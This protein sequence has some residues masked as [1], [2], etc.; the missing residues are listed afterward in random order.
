MNKLQELVDKRNTLWAQMQEVATGG[1]ADAAQREQYTQLE[2]ELD[3]NEAAIAVEERHIERA[4]TFA[5]R[6][7]LPADNGPAADDAPEYNSVFEKWLRHGITELDPQERTVLQTGAISHDQ[8]FQV[9]GGMSAGEKRALGTLAG[10]AGGFTVPEG[11]WNQIVEARKAFG[12]LRNAPTFKLQTG[13]GNDIPVPTDDETGVAGEYIGENQLVGEQDIAFGQKTLKAFTLTSKIVRVPFQLLQDSAFDIEAH[14]ARKLG[15]RI[16]RA[17]AT[18]FATGTGLDEPE[19][20]LTAAPVGYTVTGT[21]SFVYADF[22]NIVHS[23]DPDYRQDPS[24]AF[25]M[26]D[27]ALKAARLITISSS[28]DRPLWQPGLTVGE[29]NTI[30]Q[31]SYWVDNG[32]D[33]VATGNTPMVF[34]ALANFW[35]RDVMGVQLMRLDERYAEY[36]Q[37]AFLAFARNDSKLIDAGQGPIRA[38]KMA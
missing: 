5:G 16:G 38:L 36:G 31:Y 34:G 4:Q 13:Q 3:E 32:F 29:P 12:G 28:D 6:E 19:G 22:V 2:T 18:K 27:D 11:F 30:L 9:R 33:L 37:V 8:P 23:V 15:Q 25:V 26:S 14:V 10:T 1:F 7:N 17:E 20:I 21:S 24:T 35:I